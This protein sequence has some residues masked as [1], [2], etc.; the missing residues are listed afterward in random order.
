MAP[1]VNSAEYG[2]IISAEYG[3]ITPLGQEKAE[4]DPVSHTTRAG[5]F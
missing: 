3:D 4:S 2:D 5:E 1:T